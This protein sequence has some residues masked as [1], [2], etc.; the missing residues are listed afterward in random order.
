MDLL[1]MTWL[2]NLTKTYLGELSKSGGT[3]LCSPRD[4][5]DNE[6]AVWAVLSP[7]WPVNTHRSR[8]MLKRH[9][10]DWVDF[11]SKDASVS[12]GAS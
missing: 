11:F 10:Y 5:V 12:Y 6:A 7:Y 2:Y 1:S 8:Q 9:G 3:S 4:K